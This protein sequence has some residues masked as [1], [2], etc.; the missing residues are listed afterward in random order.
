M[1][2]NYSVICWGQLVHLSMKCCSPAATGQVWL[3]NTSNV[4]SKT[5][6]LN[7]F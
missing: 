1:T 2:T 4:A 3:F 6:E 5:E 7:L